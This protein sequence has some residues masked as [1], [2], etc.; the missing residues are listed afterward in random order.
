MDRADAAPAETRV[1]ETLTPE[2]LLPDELLETFRA[3]AGGYD[4]ENRFFDEDFADLVRIGYPLMLVPREFGG[5]GFT[6]RQAAAA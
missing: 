5:L 3:R 1:G 6:L 2:T 4:R